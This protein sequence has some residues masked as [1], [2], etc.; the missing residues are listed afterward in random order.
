MELYNINVTVA[1]GQPIDIPAYTNFRVVPANSVINVA[2]ALPF[3]SLSGTVVDPDVV[4]MGF[5]PPGVANSASPTPVSFVYTYGAT[6]PDPTYT[7]VRDSLGHYHA[8]FD[9]SS[10]PTGAWKVY[11]S[12]APGTSGHDT[13][14]TK[15]YYDQG[16]IVSAY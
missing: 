8:Q 9:V 1:T 4:T 13:T 11:I 7:V 16:F 3:T 2:L 10:Y 12:G 6:P 5:L 15:I 14:K